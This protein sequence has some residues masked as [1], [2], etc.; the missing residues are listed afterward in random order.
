MSYSYERVQQRRRT[1]A[2]GGY[3]ASSRRSTLGYWVPLIMTVTVATIGIAAWIWSERR[4]D[5]D[6]TSD[7]DKISNDV[8]PTGYPS[9]S[10][11][12]PPGPGPGGFQGPPPSGSMGPGGYEIPPMPTSGPGYAGGA[13][14]AATG[15]HGQDDGNLMSRMS[16]AFKRTPSPQQSYDWASR[17]VAAGVAA[18][19]AVVGGALTAIREGSQEDY[20]DH[21]RWSEEAD[22]RDNSK[23]PNRGIKRRGTA[24]DYF[25]GAVG[26]PQSAATHLR[27]RKNVAL[28][29]SAVESGSDGVGEVG[30]HAASIPT[31]HAKLA[32]DIGPVNPCPLARIRQTRDYKSFCP[33]IRA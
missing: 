22:S 21:E 18:A 32:T 31:I 28:V 25:S 27:N 14:S 17:K 10:A 11:G 16:G 3:G 13:R 7:E 29:V 4:D 19:G 5:E 15:T 12:L 20:G 6:E 23:E 26:M 30:Q 1:G 2:G 24:E 8:P 9:M 33:D